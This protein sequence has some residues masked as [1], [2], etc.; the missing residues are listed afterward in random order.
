MTIPKTAKFAAAILGL[1]LAGCSI[2]DTL[3]LG[4]DDP[5]TSLKGIVADYPSGFE[6]YRGSSNGFSSV[7]VYTTK[8]QIVKGHCEVW[9]WA[10]DDSAYVCSG[11]TPNNE[12]AT[13]RYNTAVNWMGQ[14]LGNGWTSTEGER[15]RDGENAGTVTRFRSNEAGQPNVSVHRVAFRGDSAV[16]VYV[17]TPSRLAEF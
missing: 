7:T 14:C 2:Q 13:T 10:N 3:S 8:E 12:V 9:S 17:G 11:N 1:S 15:T 4:V 5:C 6:Q 16:Y